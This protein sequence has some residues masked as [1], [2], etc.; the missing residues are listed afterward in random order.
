MFFIPQRILDLSQTTET[1]D[2]KNIDGYNYK[3]QI[4]ENL[5]GDY[6]EAIS[7]HWQ[8]YMPFVERF[9]ELY[10]EPPFNYKKFLDFAKNHIGI[11]CTVHTFNKD[12]LELAGI[13]LTT[14]TRGTWHWNDAE[15]SDISI[16][17]NTDFPQHTYSATII[18]E[19]IH[20]IQDFDYAF[21]EI[22][23][24][25]PIPLQLRIAERI[26]EKTA[27]SILLPPKLLEQDRRNQLRPHQVALKYGV[28]LQMAGYELE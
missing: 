10:P 7:T 28:S 25:Y 13:D 24:T 18:H 9:H 20:A 11:T 15:K 22:L 3:F 26:A 14:E 23:R 1:Y 17:V 27:I 21:H 4:P 16:W 6:Q 19:V 5:L 2:P 12:S 8:R